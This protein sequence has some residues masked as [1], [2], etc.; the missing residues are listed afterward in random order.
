MDPLTSFWWRRSWDQTG[1]DFRCWGPALSLSC[2]W[3]PQLGDPAHSAGH[4]SVTGSEWGLLI[5]PVISWEEDKFLLFELP[6]VRPVPART[7]V[8][9]AAS[10]NQQPQLCPV[11]PCP[12]LPAQLLEKT[13]QVQLPSME[14][15]LKKKR[16]RPPN[17]DCRSYF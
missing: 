3:A 13:L 17:M 15:V 7:E 9:P 14:S 12:A 2:S 16:K 8:P 6:K 10:N 5:F 11:G 1:P 4:T